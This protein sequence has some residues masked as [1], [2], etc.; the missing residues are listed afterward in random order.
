M[1]HLKEYLVLLRVAGLIA[2]IRPSL[3]PDLI[4]QINSL[5]AV[6]SDAQQ[7]VDS[8]QR[9]SSP[10]P[11][12]RSPS[13]NV[14]SQRGRS[15]STA[16]NQSFFPSED[17]SIEDALPSD[18]EEDIYSQRQCSIDVLASSDEESNIVEVQYVMSQLK[19]ISLG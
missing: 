7:P 19:S 10:S 15:L 5:L 3:D 16:S 2:T 11:Q 4:D 1:S 18:E 13:Y 12:R 9:H 8:H 6:R 17:P 14:P